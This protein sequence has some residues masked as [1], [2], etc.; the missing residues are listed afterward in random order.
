MQ[1]PITLFEQEAPP[2]PELVKARTTLMK[3]KIDMCSS[4]FKM[5]LVEEPEFLLPPP[6]KQVP[7]QLNSSSL[8][9]YPT[10]VPSF[11]NF[12]KPECPNY[13]PQLNYIGR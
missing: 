12:D 6:A 5:A 7:S 4:L 1:T 2:A 10:K 13:S 11:S 3:P 8:P 9:F